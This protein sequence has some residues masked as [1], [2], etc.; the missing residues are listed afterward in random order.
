MIIGRGFSG[1]F[2]HTDF[3]FYKFIGHE[4]FVCFFSFFLRDRNWGMVVDLLDEDLYV[5]NQ[6]VQGLVPFYN[7]SKYVRL[8]NDERN[9]RLGL[10]C[11]SVEADIL[12]Q[13]YSQGELAS[14]LTFQEFMETD[15]FLYLRTEFQ[16]QGGPGDYKWFPFSAVHM[17]ESPLYLVEAERMKY[18]NMLLSPLMVKNTIVLQQKLPGI[19][20]KLSAYYDKGFAIFSNP[21]GN[22][23]PTKI[24]SRT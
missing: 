4:L 3:D 20:N 18:A 8:L 1:F 14:L 24:A 12:K 9:L 2:L 15:L 6:T 16:L 19:V 7:V 21:L 13:R 23:D 5:S 10:N 17:S 22:Y 11:I